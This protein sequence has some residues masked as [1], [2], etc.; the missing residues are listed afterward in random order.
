MNSKQEKRF[1][2]LEAKTDR[3][4]QEEAVRLA[5]LSL[6][7]KNEAVDEAIEDQPANSEAIASAKAAVVEARK[8]LA[9][10]EAAI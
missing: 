2:E 10:A 8:V 6:D 9:D 5:L 7:E 4:P 3:T 1:Q